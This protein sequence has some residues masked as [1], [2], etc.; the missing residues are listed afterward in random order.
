VRQ[1][2]LPA[3]L[4]FPHFPLVCVRG[5]LARVQ[6]GKPAPLGATWDGQGVN[7]ALYSE[8]ATAVDLCLFDDVADEREPERLRLVEVTAHVWHG[9]VPGLRPG[10]LYGY[11]V[12]GPYA[13][14]Q[15]LRFNPAK[16]L[17]DPY[18]RAVAGEVAWE[19]PVFAY[20]PGSADLDLDLDVNDED[21]AWGVPKGVVV[22]GFF[23]W[24]NDRP[25]RTAWPDSVIYEVHVKGFT[26]RHPDLPPEVQGTYAA[27]GSPVAVNYLKSLGITA[28]ELLPVHAHLNDKFLLDRGLTNYWG[29]NTLS[30]FAPEGRYAISATRGE[31]VVEFK[32]MV[33]ALHA[34]GIEVVLDVVYN[35]TCE[36]NHLGP[37][38]SLKGIDNP[39]YYRLVADNPRYYMDYTGTG[40][41]LNARH[42]QALKL[43]MDSLRYWVTEMHVDGFRFDLASTLARELHEVDRLSAFFDIIHQDP[44]LSEVKL[45]AEPWDV[46]EGGYQVG[47]FPVLWAE[48]NGRYRDTVRRYWKGDEGQIT[49]LAF[50]LAGSSDL[51]Q[52]DGRRPSA[53]INYIISH[54]G[55][56]LRDQVSYN[57]KHNEANKEENRD[58]TND[59]YSW[60]C[61][62]EGPT[63]S[64][65]VI[66]LRDQQE[67]NFLATLFISQG[68][69][70]LCGGDEIGRTQM[71][72]NNAYCHDDEISWFNWNPTERDMRLLEFTR[73]MI[74]LRREQPVL[75]RRKFFQGRRVP[76][77]N[78][79]DVSWV[80]PD[81]REM[82]RPDWNQFY[83]R[84]LGM[85]LEGRGVGF[86]DEEG[87]P[88][89]SDT[90]LILMNAGSD[91]I[92]FRL[93]VASGGQ[94]EVWAD[95]ARSE[96]NGGDQ[97]FRG[98]S[99]YNLA[100]R[101]LV[102]MRRRPPERETGANRE[103]MRMNQ[104]ASETIL[105]NVLEQIRT[106]RRLPTSTYRIQFNSSFTFQDARR[107]V[108]YLHALGIT[109]CY[110]SPYLRARPGST[111]G[112]DICDHR[113]LNPELGTEQDYEAFVEEL[114]KH[115]MGQILDVVPNHMSILETA[116]PKWANVLE[117][118]P[119]SP[120]ARFFDIDWHPLHAG[121]SLDDTVLIPVLGKS[122]GETLEDQELQL[123]YDN[124]AFF[125]GYYDHSYPVTPKS[126]TQILEI[127]AEELRRRFGDENQDVAELQSI[128][129]AISHLPD[130]T[131]K[132][133]EKIAERQREKEVIKRRVKALYDRVEP[134]QEAVNQTVSLFNGRKGDPRSFDRLHALLDQQA[135]RLAHW[136]VAAE[137]INYRRF[138]DVNELAA[139][140]TEDP[141][142]FEETHQL[143]FRLLRENK[144]MGLR[145]DHPDGLLDPGGY[146]AELQ[147]SYLLGLCRQQLPDGQENNP[148][149]VRALEEMIDTR[150]EMEKADR[151]DALVLRPLY[152]VVEKILTGGERLPTDWSVYGTTGYDFLNTANG[153]MV[154]SASARAFDILYRGFSG[155]DTGYRELVNANKKM[156]M[157]AS[158]SSEINMLAHQLK[159]I[160]SRHR[161]TRD[162]TLNSLT[163]ALREVIA[164]LPVYRTYIATDR[165]SDEHEVDSRDRSYV[166]VAVREA[167]RRNP[168][169]SAEIFG[170]IGDILLSRWSDE[171]YEEDRAA[172]L[173][174]VHRFQ[175]NSGPVMAKGVEDTAFY[176]YNRLISLNEVGGNPGQFGLTVSTFHQQSAERQKQWPYSLLA[177]S[178]HDT[179]RSEDVRARLDVLSELPQE[180]RSAVNRWSRTNRPKRAKA[181]GQFVPDG[182]DEYYLYQTLLGAWPFGDL[183]DEQYQGFVRRM[184]E[185][186]LKAARE[187][188]VNTSWVNMNQ[189][190]EEGLTRFVA[191]LLERTRTNRFLEEFLPLARKV[192]FF[193]MFNSLS[194]TLLKIASPGVPDF[195]QGTEVWDLRLVDPDNR[196]PVDYGIRIAILEQISKRIAESG[197]QLAAFARE[198]VDSAPDGRIK[199]YLIHRALTYRRQHHDLFADGAYV[200]LQGTGEGEEHLC[201]FARRKGHRAVVA[202]VPRLVAELTHGEEVAPL[203]EKVWGDGRLILPGTEPSQQYRNVFTSE[204]LS[205]EPLAEGGQTLPLSE[206]FASFPVALLERVE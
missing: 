93:P 2:T 160:A 39:T 26:R 159:R 100:A 53:S 114:K 188:K 77:S 55:F 202:V 67:R 165:G 6:S 136:R 99:S 154:N 104:L 75:R 89:E 184:Q 195:Y 95:T 143:I 51:Y 121:A 157:L 48:W 101:S 9:Y 146:F 49:D 97:L 173:E 16:L 70:M 72:N 79:K 47:N 118:G 185:H 94:W 180:W 22:D 32:A 144:V 15:G 116:N 123:R 96:G 36:G 197:K 191:E 137:E 106:T 85:Q 190:Y 117:N 168:R 31:Q 170:F 122:Y 42:P 25:P 12:Y 169:T 167:K 145:V 156:I 37:T 33:K 147:K 50:R 23:D 166:E 196:H 192:A 1:A 5:H 66:A 87:M 91:A 161:R 76:G 135:F 155:R 83:A 10:Q 17:L 199:M 206:L 108:S 152:V 81:G 74:R 41:S 34:A 64:S 58:G 158:L 194:Q 3:R 140:R 11:R 44:L 200:P 193:G 148:D 28:V 128:I 177:T 65:E 175:Q 20:E 126:Y 43:I 172:L 52:D 102:L 109:D 18:A 71:G 46:G 61:G 57:E 90:L 189:A 110:S 112:Y 98:G 59:N 105:D 60:N 115:E 174:F 30:Y 103:V 138:F 139:I 179:K 183:D 182:N 181:E 35:H 113:V 127:P 84:V 133:P 124:G 198:L 201:A 68:V 19:A 88:A 203:G 56:T 171:E 204:T 111:H 29:Y 134:V 125:V 78:A 151:P 21:D 82:A 69:P 62:V 54:D 86:V 150:F 92:P 73:R 107:I 142:V 13:P 130:R 4:A 163:F 149:R 164:A 27:M 176:T 8:N 40:N 141:D 80:R 129:T 131:E 24:G 45:I 153:I 205:P 132:D 14:E 178:T 7:F 38:L 187:A 119:A 63:H 120:Y 186:A 162:F